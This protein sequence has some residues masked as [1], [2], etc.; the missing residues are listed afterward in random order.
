M[1][2][3]NA[4]SARRDAFTLIELLVVIAII[5]IL[6]AML[7]PALSKAKSKA[8]GVKCMSN[9]K[10]IQLAWQMYPDDFGGW[11]VPNGALNAP[12]N[13]SWVTGE[14]MGWGNQ[15]INTN[16]AK[17]KSGLLSP[18][19][20]H[21]VGAYKCP[22]DN[23]PSANG[24]RVRSYSMNSQ[25][26]FES[27]ADYTPPNYNEGY[28]NYKKFTD[29]KRPPPSMAWVFVDEHP[30]S[31]NDGYFQ[32]SMVNDSFP[33]VPASYHNRACG[34]SFADGHAEIHRWL[35]RETVQPVT[36]GVSVQDVV[37]GSDKRDI[38]WLQERSSAKQ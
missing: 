17:L 18:Y 14:F 2:A 11:L 33:D 28:L 22:A 36:A 10:Q 27:T 7:L 37:V 9:V 8:E 25:M 20:N 13:F 16:I 12:T 35:A 19:L 1:K 15:N 6:A 21:G 3:A 32:V 38:R 34:F 26:G 31:I 29:I 30:G 23:V 4:V 24:Q 5:A